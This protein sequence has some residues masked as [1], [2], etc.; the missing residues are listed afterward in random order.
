[1][2]SLEYE[3]FYDKV[4]KANGWDFSKLKVVA[5]GV[6]WDFYEKVVELCK[7]TDLLLDVGTG[8]GEALLSIADCARLLVGIDLSESMV[9]TATSNLAASNKSNVRFIRMDAG[10]L[11]FP[12]N[13]FDMVSCR[14]SGFN[15]Q[16]VARVLTDEGVFL[17]QQV[18]ESDKLNLK[19]AFG[20]GQAQG[21]EEGTLHNRYRTELREAGFTDILSYEYDA[22]EYYRTPE[23]LIFLLKHTPIVPYFGQ[24]DADF[25]IL[26]QFVEDNRMEKGIRTNSK[27]FMLIAKK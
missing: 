27:R 10:K 13:F 3:Q 1:M 16:E 5:E 9:E 18:S 8:G 26:R 15:A 11:M 2:N 22:T 19:E 21:T 23:D 4:G 14:H 24:T 6:K 7:P 25:Q 17:T 12:G 20:R